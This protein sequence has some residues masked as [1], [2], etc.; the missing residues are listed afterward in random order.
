MSPFRRSKRRNPPGPLSLTPLGDLPRI[1]RDPLNVF[2]A[3]RARYGDVVRFRGGIWY[4][5]LVT[6]PNDVKHIL[7]E[8]YQNYHKGVTYQY[9][10]PVVGLG[11][12]TNE[13]ESWLQQRRLAQPAFH[14]QRIADISG[15]MSDA[16]ERMV[17]RWQAPAAAGEALD[18]AAEMMRLALEIVGL[19]LLGS[20]LG[21]EADAVREAVRIGQ[22]HVNHRATHIITLD[23]KY[24]TPANRR[25][26]A[27]L[28]VLDDVVYRVIEERRRKEE[29][30][31][32]LLSML[33][34]ARDEVTGEGMND[35]QLRDEVMTIFLAGHE[36][37]ANALA[38]AW[39]LLS[40]HPEAERRLHDELDSVLAGRR[41]EAS[42][43]THQHGP[44]AASHSPMTW[45]V[46]T[47]CRAIS[48]CC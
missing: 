42:D 44:S 24:P 30:T 15:V 2:M 20:D 41:P 35:K 34:L 28:R 8:N 32:D 45:S 14:R 16:A 7:Q 48:R 9:L 10:K 47:T 27:A 46:A 31:G 38:W 6:H 25:F 18:V 12:L 21:G 23:E 43:F 37:T 11:L 19:T 29:D 1:Q 3:A 40:Q 22:E 4:A 26:K 5:Y 13:G 39:Y 33:L 36:T 17:E